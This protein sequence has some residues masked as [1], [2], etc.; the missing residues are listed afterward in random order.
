MKKKIKDLTLDDYKSYTKKYCDSYY[1]EE[2]PFR[3]A[4]CQEDTEYFWMNHKDE[5]SDEFLNQ[6]IDMVLPILLEKEQEYLKNILE[7][8]KDRVRSIR[9]VEC[10]YNLEQIFINI[11]F[12]YVVPNGEKIKTIFIIKM[13]PFAKNTMYK[14]MELDIFYTQSELGLW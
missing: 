2:C 5:Y 7:P 14:N 10:G 4:A 3:R 6:E 1:C 9:K 8:F 12:E 13:P 11:Y